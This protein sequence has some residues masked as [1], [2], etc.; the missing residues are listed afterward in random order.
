MKFSQLAILTSVL[1]FI[2]ASLWLFFPEQLL[3][4]W[5]IEPTAGTGVISRRSAAFF[6]GIGVMCL[7]ARNAEPSLT[8]YALAAGISTI[9]LFLAVLGIVEWREGHVNGRIFFAVFIELFLGIAF[10]LSNRAV[11]KNFT[12]KRDRVNNK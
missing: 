1:F 4:Q 9:S 3:T 10:L 8:R 5:G 7:F 2:L 12:D 11:K 6:A